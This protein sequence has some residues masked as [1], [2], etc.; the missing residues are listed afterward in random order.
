[1][2]LAFRLLWTFCLE[3]SSCFQT[4][5]LLL[6]LLLFLKRRQ[7]PGR[8]LAPLA[9]HIAANRISLIAPRPAHRRR[10]T[11]DPV[12]WR[13][14]PQSAAAEAGGYERLPLGG[15]DVMRWRR[16]DQRRGHM[17]TC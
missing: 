12:T 7:L 14:N 10:P 4:L 11:D 5:L 3:P 16:W 2:S 13:G 8:H 15:W 1:M 17:T 6:L 9:C